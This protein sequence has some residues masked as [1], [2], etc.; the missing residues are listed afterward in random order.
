MRELTSLE[1]GNVFG[2]ISFSTGSVSAQL[3][4]LNGLTSS[5]GYLWGNIIKTQ[6]STIAGFVGSMVL[7]MASGVVGDKI[8]QVSNTSVGV[9]V[10]VTGTNYTS[11]TVSAGF[12]RLAQL[13]AERLSHEMAEYGL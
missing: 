9:G 11:A 10:A 2:G 8:S 13:G 1:L 5:G 4:A 12:E 7:G 6:E 3:I